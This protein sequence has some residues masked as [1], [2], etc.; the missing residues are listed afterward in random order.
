MSLTK[1]R[2]V[3]IGGLHFD[4]M[5]LVIMEM[6]HIEKRSSLFWQPQCKSFIA[7]AKDF[8]ASPTFVHSNNLNFLD[9]KKVL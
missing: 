3:P 7:L 2:V 4:K 6:W 9:E 8:F 1:E 5:H